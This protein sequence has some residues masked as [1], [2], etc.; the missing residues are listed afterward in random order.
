MDLF[1]I[2]SNPAL[3]KKVIDALKI[4]VE[5]EIGRPGDTFNFIVGLEARGFVLGPILALEYGLPF[6]GIRKKGKLPGDVIQQEYTLE[7]GTDVVEIQKGV[8]NSKSKV[9][10][11]DDLLAT[12]GTLAAAISLIEKCDGAQVTGSAVV[13]DVPQLKGR[14]KLKKSCY[15]LISLKD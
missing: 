13:F 4:M 7:Y 12:G 10:L 6:T 8:L 15:S 9:L 2:S 1:S 11:I 3:F 5:C 14:D